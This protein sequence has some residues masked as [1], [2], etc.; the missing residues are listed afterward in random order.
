LV[1]NDDCW[2]TKQLPSLVNQTTS[3][4][5]TKQISCLRCGG[6][7]GMF[8][9]DLAASCAGGAAARRWEM[10]G[11]RDQTWRAGTSFTYPLVMSK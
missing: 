9:I 1:I 8:S 10:I 7:C 5:T 4:E 11:D 6:L 3:L 2:L